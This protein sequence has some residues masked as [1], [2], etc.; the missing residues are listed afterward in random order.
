METKQCR[1]IWHVNESRRL[2]FCKGPKV[3]VKLQEG[4]SGKYPIGVLEARDAAFVSISSV[5]YFC[6]GKQPDDLRV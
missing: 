3:P 1:T 6:I 5:K 4:K 2:D